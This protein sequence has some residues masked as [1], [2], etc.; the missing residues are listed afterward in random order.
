MTV[1]IHDDMDLE[2]IA[3]SGQCFRM[4]ETSPGTW[5]VLS[6][7]QMLFIRKVEGPRFQVS[8]SESEWDT[9]WYP[10]FDLD[11][12]YSAIREKYKGRNEFTDR[13]MDAGRGLRILRADPF[14]MLITFI[15]SQ[16][17]NIPAISASVEK[18]C[19][20]YGHMIGRDE[21]QDIYSF[22]TAEEMTRADEKGLS[23]CS[24][25]YRTPYILD[26]VSRVSD[27]RLNFEKMRKLDDRQLFDTLCTV[28]GVGVKV[29][30]C[31]ELFGYART[32]R[33]PVDVWIQRAIDQHYGG[34]NPFSE[35]GDEAGIIQQYIFYA[36]RHSV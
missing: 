9:I 11:R 6:R 28:K 34:V 16:R 13:C 5:R 12:N 14:E 19:K 1:D 30:N 33:A 20:R 15:I 27:G 25:G 21:D 18:I 10:Y 22:P 7:D 35:Y 2:K 8:C 29:A 23:E 31:V 24:L 3:E 26:A 4:K 36:M 32:S 17:K